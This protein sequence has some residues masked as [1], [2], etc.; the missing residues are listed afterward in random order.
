M[1]PT[2]KSTTIAARSMATKRAI[3]SVPPSI[4]WAVAGAILAQPSNERT[5]SGRIHLDDLYHA[6]LFMVHHM[7]VEHEAAGKVEEA[8]AEGHAAILRHH[9]RVAPIPLGERL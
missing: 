7:A 4:R 8:G 9:H 5:T 1:S 2:I 3:V 6:E